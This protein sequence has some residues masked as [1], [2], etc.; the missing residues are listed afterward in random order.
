MKKK[1]KENRHGKEQN[2]T[3]LVFVF[4]LRGV[5]SVWGVIEGGG[6]GGGGGHERFSSGNVLTSLNMLL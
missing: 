2:P 4:F 6:G 1:H 5:T 3:S